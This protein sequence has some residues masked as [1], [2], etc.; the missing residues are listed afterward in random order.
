MNWKVVLKELDKTEER[1]IFALMSVSLSILFI[2]VVTRYL[3][4]Y[5]FSWGE[6]LV[7]VFFVWVTMMGISLCGKYGM[8]ITIDAL[9][10][11]LPKKVIRVN[12]IIANI[13]T[14]LIGLFL[15]FLI[16]QLIKMQVA[17]S[18]MFST[19]PWLPVWTMYVAGA[20]GMAGLAVRTAV[21]SLW[22]LLTGRPPVYANVDDGSGEV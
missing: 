20:L 9:N 16:F 8:H 21:H 3:F 17:N 22:P 11:V 15:S 4:A 10:L 7:R 19:M 14:I 18:Q 6:Q 12:D 13:V 2:Q 1:V 5:S